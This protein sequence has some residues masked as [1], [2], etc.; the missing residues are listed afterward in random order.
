MEQNYSSTKLPTVAS[1]AGGGGKFGGDP[2]SNPSY[3]TVNDDTSATWGAYMAGQESSITGSS[4]GF[5]KLPDSAVIDGI[6]VFV[7]GSQVGCY[8]SVGIN[9][10]GTSSK[11]IGALNG[12][13][14]G[15]TDLW[16]ATE[17]TPTDIATIS[18]SVGVG[19]VSGGDGVASIDYME[20]TV[21][22]HIEVTAAPA[23]VPTRVVYKVYSRD[24]NYLGNLPN[25]SSKLSFSQDINSAGSSIQITCGK[26]VN[27]ET[28]VEPLQ[29]NNGDPILTSA[30][31]PIMA[32]S[33]NLLVTEGSS[34]DEAMFKNSNRIKAYVYNKWYP[35]G[36]LV[37]SGQVNKVAFK[38]GGGDATVSLIVYSDG[39]DLDN[40]IAR[41]YP[42]TYT[43]FASMTTA[44]D[45]VTATFDGGKSFA[46]Q[47]FGQTFKTGVS[48]NNVGAIRLKLKGTATVTLKLYDA[49]NGDELASVTKS[50]SFASATEVEFQFSS[51]VEVLPS[52]QYFFAIWLERGQ[53]IQIWRQYISEYYAD[54][55]RWNS[56]YGGGSGGGSFVPDPPQYDLWFVAKSGQP[57]TTTTY[58]TQDPVTGMAHGV[59][60]DYNSRGGKI[61]ERDFTATGLS[62]TYTFS[63]ATILDVIKKV[64]DMSPN[65]YYSYIDLGTAEIDIKPTSVTPDFTIIRGKEI[66]ELTIALSIEQVK[67][68]LLLSGGDTGGGVNLFRDYRDS[69]SVSNYGIRLAQKSD[70]RI[71]LA[72]TADAVGDSFIDEFSEETQETSVTVL[73]DLIDISLLTPGKTIGFKNFGNFIDDM[74]LQIAR[75]EPNFSD[76]LVHIVLGR[77]P[78]RLTDEIQRINRDLL[79]EQTIKNPS[80]PS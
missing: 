49:P 48:T 7:D 32:R 70:N 54:G 45:G 26:F 36:K 28:I 62:L 9:I 6:E 79:L 53:S 73:N 3:I 15:P 38:Y 57:T 68:Y 46:W 1:S 65:G 44:T 59:L 16:G 25:V 69:N 61:I 4:F 77:L 5:P 22:W 40:Y 37:F 35:N 12:S 42:F 20:I 30:G 51:L 24:N 13:F 23:D 58:S 33:T 71:T 67:N 2:W 52:T 8:G 50:V 31:A 74:V 29:D 10:A 76:G 64:L 66:N 43:T 27:N 21:Y 14:G 78:L 19:D 75:R 18:A 34:T 72:T 60:L 63:S 55:R 11:S 17:I 80:S 39:L 56:T 41:G 47:T